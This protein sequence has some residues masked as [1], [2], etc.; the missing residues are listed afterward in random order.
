MNC[1]AVL[2][3]LEDRFKV[4]PLSIYVKAADA[5]ALQQ[6]VCDKMFR[7]LNK[8]FDQAGRLL[9]SSDQMIVEESLQSYEM[10]TTFFGAEHE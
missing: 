8:V 1:D 9:T 7:A 5:L 6:E 3:E 4:D 10:L 2:R